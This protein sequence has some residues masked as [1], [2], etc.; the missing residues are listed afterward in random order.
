MKH[1]PTKKDSHTAEIAAG[2]FAALIGLTL[3]L[4]LRFDFDSDIGHFT[5]NS[6]FFLC[7]AFLIG[8]SVLSGVCFALIAKQKNAASPTPLSEGVSACIAPCA[9]A[10]SALLLFIM[11]LSALSRP[12][13]TTLGAILLLPGISAFYILGILPSFRGGKLHAAAGILGTL[14]VNCLIF[15]SYFDF[16]LPLNSPIRNALIVMEAA[17]L[18]SLLFTTGS[19]LGK[20]SA[21]MCHFVKLIGIALSGGI[22]FGLLLAAAFAPQNVPVGVSVLRCVLCL[23]SAAA[24][25]FQPFTYPNS[26]APS[27]NA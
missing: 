20:T 19:I 13:V 21:P 18:L 11:N 2:L 8:A 6:P 17:Y 22:A 23:F 5:K 12:S 1:T 10:L 25:Y 16:T 26:N 9:A 7:F 14:S 27:Q 15:N 24:L 4:A 3:F